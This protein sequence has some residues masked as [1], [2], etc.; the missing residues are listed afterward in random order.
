M[1]PRTLYLTK[2]EH[3]YVFRYEDGGED[4]VIEAIVRLADDPDSGL[5]WADAASLGFQ[6]AHYAAEG[7]RAQLAPADLSAADFSPLDDG[8][9]AGLDDAMEGS[10]DSFL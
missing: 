4:R 10:C 8:S 5:D 3:H 6:V 7:C 9:S 2:G 1:T